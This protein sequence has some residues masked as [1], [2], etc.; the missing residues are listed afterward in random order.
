[1]CGLVAA[2]SCS[3]NTEEI[4]MHFPSAG[5]S[6]HGE[7]QLETAGRQSTHGLFQLLYPWK[8]C[9]TPHS[10]EESHCWEFRIASIEA[11]VNNLRAK[12]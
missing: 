9:L 5:Q 3:D 4:Y 12:L 6:E 11:A 7:M 2:Y 1:M 8:H 10:G